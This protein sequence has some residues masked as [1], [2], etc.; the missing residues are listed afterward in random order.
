MATTQSSKKNE[1]GI[2]MHKNYLSSGEFAKLCDTSKETLRHYK[3][4]ELLIP[5]HIGENGYQYYEAEQFY[6]YYAINMFKK[7]G[8]PL[9]QIKACIAHQK[10]PAILSTL[11]EQQIALAEEKRKIEQ[12]QF[13]VK[14][15]IRN[16]SAGLANENDDLKPQ[17]DFF[18]KEHLLAVPRHEFFISQEDQKD[19]DRILIAVLR[20]YK[21][22]CDQYHVHTDYQLGAISQL[23]SK[24][25]THIYTKVNR[26]YKNPYYV[27]KP[28]GKYLYIIQRGSWDSSIAYQALI[29]YIQQHAI[30]TIGEIYAYDLAGFMIN[31][32]ESNCMTRISVRLNY[33]HFHDV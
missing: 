26:N 3:D 18:D 8:T 12:M 7:T 10:I 29:Q 25:I 28:A 1:M 31:G 21:E 17:I 6:D 33:H 23:Q 9:T 13:V 16:M 15:S 19:E 5:E 20:K 24:N 32:I 14:N 22:I 11:K 30:K 27:E 2:C 4:I